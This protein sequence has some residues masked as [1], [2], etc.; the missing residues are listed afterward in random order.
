MKFSGIWQNR[1]TN[2]EIKI[3]GP[4][5]SDDYWL[6]YDNDKERIFIFRSNEKHALLT[7][8]KKFGRTDIFI[9]SSNIIKIGS[10]VFDRK[11]EV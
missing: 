2:E 3:F 11:L 10:I 5:G 4:L 9:I 1:Y 7:D 6:E 8:S